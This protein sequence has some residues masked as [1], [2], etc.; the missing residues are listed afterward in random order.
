MQNWNMDFN[1]Q[2]QNCE[3]HYLFWSNDPFFNS[4]EMAHFIYQIPFSYK[5]KNTFWNESDEY[6]KKGL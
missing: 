6:V 2:S 5:G 4:I 1:D 3:M